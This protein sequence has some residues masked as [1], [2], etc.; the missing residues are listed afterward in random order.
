[1][2]PTQHFN[3]T[4]HSA[5][6][7][8]S[9]GQSSGAYF[10]NSFR[11]SAW[12]WFMWTIKVLY[13]M[14]YINLFMKEKCILWILNTLKIVAV[15]SGNG[16]VYS[17]WSN[18]VHDCKRILRHT[19]VNLEHDTSLLH[20]FVSGNVVSI[21]QDSFLPAWCAYPLLYLYFVW[22]QIKYAWHTPF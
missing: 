11:I 1:M 6:C 13:W 9:H 10:Y 8:V 21:G 12:W 14:L 16:I 17:S 2:L 22:H 3:V 18:V 19:S 5:T 20:F 4:P 7:F 15:Y